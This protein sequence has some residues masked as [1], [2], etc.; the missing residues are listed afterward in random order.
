MAAVLHPVQGTG[1]GAGGDAG[2]KPG[3]RSEDQG[4]RAPAQLSAGELKSMLGQCLQMASE[5]KIT[6]HNTWGLPLI[7]HLEDLIQEEGAVRRTNFQKASVTLDAGVKIYSYRVDSVHM[8]TFKM[9]GGLGRAGIDGVEGGEGAGG[10]ELGDG[11]VGAKSLKK[12]R[13]G[14]LQPEATLES[15]LEALNVKKFDLA[16]AVDP[17]FHK[18]SAQFDEG[19]AHG[20]L[21]NNLSVYKGCNI[22]FDS[23]DVPERAV[24]DAALEGVVDGT[25]RSHSAACVREECEGIVGLLERNELEHARI[26]PLLDEITGISSVSNA[27]NPSS[28]IAKATCPA[29]ELVARAL[30]AAEVSRGAAGGSGSVD[31]LNSLFAAMHVPEAFVPSGDIIDSAGVDGGEVGGADGHPGHGGDWGGYDDY[32]HD[33]QDGGVDDHRGPYD[34]DHDALGEDAIHWLV[35]AGGDS[36]LNLDN[37]KNMS[38][39]GASHWKYRMTAADGGGGPQKR[40]SQISKGNARNVP[41]PLDFTILTDIEE[42]PRIELDTSKRRKRAE[43]KTTAPDD[44]KTLLPED[45]K[46]A[47]STLGKY[48]LRKEYIAILRGAGRGERGA[49]GGQGDVGNLDSAADFG[50]DEGFSYGPSDPSD[51]FNLN[52]AGDD[53]DWAVG[54]RAGNVE[55]AQASHTVEHI[56]VSYCKAAKQ[57]DVKALKELMWRGITLVVEK[58]VEQGLHHPRDDIHFSDVLATVPVDNHA[59]RLEDLSVHLCFICLLHLANEHGLVVQGVDRLDGLVIGNVPVVVAD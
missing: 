58:R 18:T 30:H 13:R 41:E 29:G 16:F 39:T 12:K 26:A 53:D 27:S 23:M 37:A 33:A 15:S 5:N 47:V 14:D 6:A 40:G 19:G 59:G 42:A 20:L 25:S 57:V 36:R 55:V 54:N 4:S 49:A 2:R 51:A 1:K 22:V 3:D 11:G 34:H 35:R 45:F 52:G 28:S 46:Y 48:N 17:L 21:L 38:W 31:D 7:E 24:G 56:E 44:S 50:G 32:G 43:K 8:E 10:A 9:L